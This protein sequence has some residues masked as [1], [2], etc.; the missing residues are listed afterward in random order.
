METTM[1]MF[2]YEEKNAFGKFS[3]R[4]AHDDAP[5]SKTPAGT[6][7]EI[8]N[9][10]PVPLEMQAF[11]LSDLQ[12]HFNPTAPATATASAALK[13]SQITPFDDSE[14]YL[15]YALAHGATVG[16]TADYEFT[17]AKLISFMRSMMNPEFY[18]TALANE[19]HRRNVEAGWWTDLHTGEDLHGKR[20]VGEMLCLVHSEI[21]EAME[22]HRKRLM[23]DKLSHRPM[24][25]VELIDAVIRILD[26]LGSEGNVDHPAGRIF[27]EKLAYNAQRE[28][29]K[30]ENRIAAGGK[31]F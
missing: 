29:H 16:L 3:P 31:A 26:I 27:E 4:I 28:D 14:V 19:V 5:T 23:D 11:D 6:K 10:H 9:V 8:R 22:G 25:K 2:Y 1:T 15:D 18:L 21:S 20:N 7:R 24:L 12:A 17:E 30:P 13:E